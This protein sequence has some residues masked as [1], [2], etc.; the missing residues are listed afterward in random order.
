[1]INLNISKWQTQNTAIRIIHNNHFGVNVSYISL[2]Y[3]K[4]LKNLDVILGF[5]PC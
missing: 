5:F 4:M 1:M 3:S 2:F